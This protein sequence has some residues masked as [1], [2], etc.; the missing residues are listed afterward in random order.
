MKKFLSIGLFL[1]LMAAASMAVASGPDGMVDKNR[2]FQDAALAAQKY[3][4]EQMMATSAGSAAP[5]K[6]MFIISPQYHYSQHGTLSTG[7]LAP[8]D[9]KS[10]GGH[11][12]TGSIAFIF[13][14]EVSEMLSMTLAYQYAYT[15]YSGGVLIPK[16]SYD[17]GARGETEQEINTHIIAVMGDINLKN[18]GRLNLSLVQ[19]FDSVS[20]HEQIVDPAGDVVDKRSLDTYAQRVTALMAWYENDVNLNESWTL[21]PYIGW[22][23]L[24][25]HLSN[26]NALGTDEFG[27]NNAHAWIHLGGLGAKLNYSS[28]PLT[29]TLRGGV[30][31]RFTKD[32]LPGWAN[33]AIAPG[34]VQLGYNVNFD[35]T[36][37]T[38]G[39]GL[40]YASSES[41]IFSLNYDGFAGSQTDAHQVSLMAIFPF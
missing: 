8:F 15:D 25:A 6:K 21:T 34:V 3:E 9:L 11:A 12:N 29:V 26:Q 23:S 38:F 27:K 40:T 1:G 35:Q 2:A 19:G 39:A 7:T 17:A 32:D 13:N 36:V 37:A 22:R 41:C 10:G 5:P 30:N 33:R 18:Y 28:G 31:H 24:Y 4:A 20:G 14:R 16:A